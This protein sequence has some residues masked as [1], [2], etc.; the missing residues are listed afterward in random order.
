MSTA[1]IV[2]AIFTLAAVIG[3]SAMDIANK[4]EA[5]LER[6]ADETNNLRQIAEAIDKIRIQSSRRHAAKVPRETR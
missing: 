6:I 3:A 4:I 2:V 5:G 1:V